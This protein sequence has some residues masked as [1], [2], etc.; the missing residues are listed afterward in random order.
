MCLLHG[1]S[2]ASRNSA[3]CLPFTTIYIFLISSAFHWGNVTCRE[4]PLGTGPALQPRQPRPPVRSSPESCPCEESE[5]SDIRRVLSDVLSIWARWGPRR[6]HLA[7][8][9]LPPRPLSL[10]SGVYRRVYTQLLISLSSRERKEREWPDIA[11][12]AL[13]SEQCARTLLRDSA[14]A[15]EEAFDLL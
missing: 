14:N 11:E 15:V 8:D 9:S 3:V 1:S 13:L 6:A 4:L 12:D 10:S 5:V 7:A 2:Q